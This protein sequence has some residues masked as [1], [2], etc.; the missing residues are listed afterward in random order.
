MTAGPEVSNTRSRSGLAP[1]GSYVGE[2]Y[3]DTLAVNG[4]CFSNTIHGLI[5]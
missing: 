5:E 1:D 3:M 2:G 4:M